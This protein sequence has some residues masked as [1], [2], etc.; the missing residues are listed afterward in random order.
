M[1]NTARKIHQTI[2][3]SNRIIV[4]MHQNPDGDAIGSVGAIVEYLKKLDVFRHSQIDRLEQSYHQWDPEHN[5]LYYLAQD[6]DGKIQLWYWNMDTNI[7]RPTSLNEDDIQ[8]F[9]ISPDGK[10]IL[11]TTNDASRNLRVFTIN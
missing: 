1:L 7:S 4:V 11:V 3:D 10:Y 6:K 9:S 8:G 2:A 5:I